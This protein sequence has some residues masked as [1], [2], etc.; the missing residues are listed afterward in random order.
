M[1]KF[2]QPRQ[3]ELLTLE[4]DPKM[5]NSQVPVLIYRGTANGD[6]L[7]GLFRQVFSA[8]GWAGLWTGAI[9]GYDHFH[10]NA[11]EVVGVV[12][13]EAILG[14]GGATGQRVTVGEGDVVILPAGT[15]HRRVRGSSD[16]MVIGAFPVGQEEHDIYT[17]LHS[18]ADYRARIEAIPIPP[19]PAYGETGA[20]AAA[21]RR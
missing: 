3:P 7:E 8:N 5:P 15:G 14:L 4:P 1:S 2:L 16:F 10:S 6:G 13:G 11:H 18:C 17:D 21:W 20:L 19:D 9:F 12:S